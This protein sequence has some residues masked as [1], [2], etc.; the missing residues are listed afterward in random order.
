[1]GQI[2]RWI[3]LRNFY[4]TGRRS[5]SSLLLAA[6][7]D[8]KAV[9]SRVSRVTRQSYSDTHPWRERGFWLCYMLVLKLNSE[10]GTVSCLIKWVMKY[11]LSKNLAFVKYNECLK[12]RIAYFAPWN[13][14]AL[15]R[16]I[17]WGREGKMRKSKQL[18]A[19]GDAFR[20]KRGWPSVTKYHF[21]RVFVTCVVL[22]PVLAPFHF[23]EHNRR[24]GYWVNWC[25]WL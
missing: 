2:Y 11:W 21:A 10:R 25:I 12:P 16:T 3:W 6:T 7:I 13:N 24:L 5:K 14:T 18:R 20:A 22:T 19:S 4:Q 15:L 9:C 23:D 8:P 17:P 1:M